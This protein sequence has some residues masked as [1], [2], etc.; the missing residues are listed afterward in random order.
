MASNN[1]SGGTSVHHVDDQPVDAMFKT[2]EV[3]KVSG[4]D[5]VEHVTGIEV[6]GDVQRI[7]TET[8]LAMLHPAQEREGNLK[9][10]VDL[11]V[12]GKEPREPL[13]VGLANVVF[14]HINF[15]IGESR[16]KV[17]YRAEG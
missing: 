5:I 16:M 12:E 3:P 7:E 8:E 10:A 14:E 1:S 13:A 2:G 17:D 9:L 15:R 11:D 4:R 6:I